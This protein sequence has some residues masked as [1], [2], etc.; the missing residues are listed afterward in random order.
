M[1]IDQRRRAREQG[2]SNV[3]PCRRPQRRLI[4]AAIEPPPDLRK[5][6]DEV[7]RRT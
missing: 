2:L 5:D 7:F 4:K 3:E 1:M 6:L